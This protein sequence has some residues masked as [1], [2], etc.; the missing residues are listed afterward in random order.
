MFHGVEDSIVQFNE[1]YPFTDEFLPCISNLSKID[2]SLNI[3]ELHAPEACRM[4]MGNLCNWLKMV[5]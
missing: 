4:N 1:G 5:Q 2:D 3:E